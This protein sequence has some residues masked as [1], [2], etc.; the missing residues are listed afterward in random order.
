MI[1]NLF[2]VVLGL[3][4]FWILSNFLLPLGMGALLAVLLYPLHRQMSRTQVPAGLSAFSLTLF[5]MFGFLVPIAASVFLLTQSV[6]EWVGD[7][8]QAGDL[9]IQ[10]LIQ[11]LLESSWFQWIAQRLEQWFQVDLGSLI[12]GLQGTFQSVLLKV[13]TLG[14]DFLRQIPSL[15]LTLLI[16]LVGLFYFLLD[17]GRLVKFLKTHWGFDSDQGEVVGAHFVGLCRSVILA[18]VLSGLIQAIILMGFGLVLGI[19]KTFTWVM[20][21]FLTS[22][23]PLIGSAPIT[24]GLS[25]YTFIFVSSGQGIVM[26]IAALVIA[27]AD[28][29]VR[30]A[31]LKGGGDLHPLVGF[32]AALGG[33]QVMGFWGIFLGPVIAG[34]FLTALTLILK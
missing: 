4:L 8:R 28:N 17:G 27:V 7:H 30:P 18:S 20:L 25:V 1:R 11:I 9:Q 33:L 21:V 2:L 32:L 15:T 10:M 12:D 13:A 31:V 16:V 5:A 6:L 3:L 24:I 14:G 26:A 22:F 29:F 34:T 19:P 23:I